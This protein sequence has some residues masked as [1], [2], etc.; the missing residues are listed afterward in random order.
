[1]NLLFRLFYLLLTVKRR[2][3]VTALGPCVSWFRVLPNDLDILRHINNGRYFS[4]MDL[5]R[6]D[7]MAR[8]GLWRK[9]GLAGWYPVVVKESMV[10]R[11]SLKL[12]HR[13]TVRTTVIGWD[14]NHMFM[15]QLFLLG[16]TDMARGIV[17]ARML[18]KTGGS[19]GTSEIM[20]L[21]E[22]TE[23]LPLSSEELA[24]LL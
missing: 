4:I 14:A 11:K 1:M 6:V 17:K 12:W 15:E 20:A 2:S 10:F 22:H 3:S 16:E 19:V 24:L 7:L 23:P 9:F 13:Y 18:K 8:S 5:G 21:A